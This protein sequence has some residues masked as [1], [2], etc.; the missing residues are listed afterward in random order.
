MLTLDKFF[1]LKKNLWE[2][3]EFYFARRLLIIIFIHRQHGSTK[4]DSN[5]IY[6]TVTVRHI[7]STK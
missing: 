1:D 2:C 7:T 5:T 6:K 3:D 4:K